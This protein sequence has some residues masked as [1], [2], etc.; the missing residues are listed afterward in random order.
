MNND[1]TRFLAEL[2]AV[3]SAIIEL[4]KRIQALRWQYDQLK[5]APGNPE[6]ITDEQASAIGV[7]A[8]DVTTAITGVEALLTILVTQSQIAIFLK[9]AR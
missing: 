6:Q 8:A 9:L 7:K 1:K 4:C 3:A 5:Y 2:A